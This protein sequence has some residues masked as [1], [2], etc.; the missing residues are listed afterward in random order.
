MT[1]DDVSD[2][3]PAP[4]GKPKI[5]RAEQPMGSFASMNVRILELTPAQE[6]RLTSW[7]HDT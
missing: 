3:S 6:E 1:E 5:E 4:A 7:T 2:L